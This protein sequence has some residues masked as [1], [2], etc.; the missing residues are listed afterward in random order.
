MR[1]SELRTT[2][3]IVEEFLDYCCDCLQIDPKP[4]L[5]LIRDHG[6]SVKNHTFGNYDPNTNS[7]M[8]QIAHRHILDILRTLAHELVH[9]K[10]NLMGHLHQNSGRTGS[11]HEN[12]ANSIAGVIMRD[13]AKHNSHLYQW[14]PE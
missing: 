4:A 3:S 11:K 14:T 5:S 12:Q 7:I 9:H 10:Q 8:L 13:F 6:F 1:A 2:E